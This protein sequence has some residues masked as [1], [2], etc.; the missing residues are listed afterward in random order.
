LQLPRLA[1][2]ARERLAAY[3]RVA[4]GY[5]ERRELELLPVSPPI[6]GEVLRQ[7][8]AVG[9]CSGSGARDL[10][11]DTL[12]T[13]IVPRFEEMGIAAREAYRTRATG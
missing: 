10:F 9:L 4:F 11:F 5:L 12:E 6:G 7:R 1:D 3:L 13:V 2:G 8:E